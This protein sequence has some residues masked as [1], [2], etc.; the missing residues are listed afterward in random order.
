[1]TQHQSHSEWRLILRVTLVLAATA[2]PLPASAIA[3]IKTPT[4]IP[5]SILDSASAVRTAC[6]LV[7]SLRLPGLKARC[8]VESYRETPT[9]YVVRVR[10][11]A[12]PGSPPLPFPYSEVRLK[13]TGNAATVIRTPG[14]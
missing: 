1:M 10:E 13:K 14:L 2:L 6:A 4:S 12:P 5:P 9:E 7:Q 8:L 3:Q 11:Q